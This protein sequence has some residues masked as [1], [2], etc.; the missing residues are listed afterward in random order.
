MS[1]SESFALVA[2]LGP[3]SF[4]R[5][6]E[7]IAC[8]ATALRL[9]A[10]HLTPDRLRSLLDLTRRQLPATPIVI[11]LQGAKMRL[12]DFEA[13]ALTAG[14]TIACA[15]EPAGGGVIPLPHPE[16]FEQARPGETISVDDDRLR[17]RVQ[18]I[19]AERLVAVALNDGPLLPRKGVNVIEHPVILGDIGAGDLRMIAAGV[20]ISYLHWAFSFALDGREAAWLRRHVGDAPVIA[21]I[22][23]REATE[24]LD[25]LSARMDALWVCRGDLGA[26]LGSAALARFV[27]ALDPRCHRRPILMAGQVFEHLT[28]H[29][30]PTRS[31]VCHLHD[32]IARGYS[33]IVLSDETAVGAHPAHAVAIVADLIRT[34]RSG[35]AS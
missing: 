32:L 14:A 26:Q 34:L 21:K 5:A 27:A 19:S 12:G 28:E 18:D 24:Q 15:L 20:G 7:L 16:F 13:R 2:T 17:L 10:S 33:G 9:N 3:A 22:E 35:S 25:A 30:H 6:A 4:D 1:P 11:D 8:G 31:E 23:R 29:R